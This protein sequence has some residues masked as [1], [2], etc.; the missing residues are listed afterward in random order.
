MAK[1]LSIVVNSQTLAYRFLRSDKVTVSD[2]C[3][4]GQQNL[5][6]FEMRRILF[7]IS[8]L[9]SLTRRLMAWIWRTV[10]KYWMC[11]ESAKLLGRS[12]LLCYECRLILTLF[13]SCLLGSH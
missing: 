4:Y 5:L 10:M 2:S 8:A 3:C 6:N 11:S 12:V 7:G 9:H 13:H 1:H